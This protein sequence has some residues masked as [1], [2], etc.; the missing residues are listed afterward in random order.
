MLDILCFIRY[1]NITCTKDYINKMLYIFLVGVRKK[2]STANTMFLNIEFFIKT[3]LS[4]IIKTEL[5]TG[6][7]LIIS[8][9]LSIYQWWPN[10]LILG[11]RT[12]AEFFITNN[13]EKIK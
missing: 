6:I 11:E 3:A 13:I 4:F 7:S 2:C 12:E 10:D 9:S 5:L 1:K 8:I